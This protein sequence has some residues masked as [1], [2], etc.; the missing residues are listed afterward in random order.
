MTNILT[1]RVILQFKEKPDEPNSEVKYGIGSC[2]YGVLLVA[3][4]TVGICSIFIADQADK[5]RSQIKLAFPH[6]QLTEDKLALQTEFKQVTKIINEPNEKIQLKLSVSGTPFQQ[7]VWIALCNI[8]FGSTRNY[9]QLATE[10]GSPDAVRAVAS[11]CAANLLA[12]AI[13]CHRVVRSD[14]SNSGYRWGIETKQAIL[15]KEQHQ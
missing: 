15:F 3:K 9:K 1:P 6:M 2:D 12:I 13:P 4:D 8:P 5:L 11:A 14:G 7:K 10:L